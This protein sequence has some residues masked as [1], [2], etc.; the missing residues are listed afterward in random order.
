MVQPLPSVSIS[1]SS[2]NI[3]SLNGNGA[4]NGNLSKNFNRNGSLEYAENDGID[5]YIEQQRMSI[6][7]AGSFDPGFFIKL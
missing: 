4:T 3:S 7:E 5:L 1:F 2:N 6:D